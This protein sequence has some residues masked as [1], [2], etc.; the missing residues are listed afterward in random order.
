MKLL[1]CEGCG[2]SV[3]VFWVEV[4]CE[5]VVGC[6]CGDSIARICVVCECVG[7]GCVCL[8]L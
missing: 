6:G 5:S 4:C 7:I 1:V 2:V 3:C 8:V